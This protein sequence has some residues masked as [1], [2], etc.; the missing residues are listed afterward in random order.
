MTLCWFASQLRDPLSHTAHDLKREVN[1]ARHDIQIQPV[2]SWKEVRRGF[3]QIFPA[4]SS[5]L[6][7]NSGP[8]RSIKLGQINIS[9]WWKEETLSPNTRSFI[10]FNCWGLT[11]VGRKGSKHKLSR[12]QS[13]ILGGLPWNW[14][15][16]SSFSQDELWL[17]NFPY[18]T[19]MKSDFKF[20]QYF[21]FSFYDPVP[22]KLSTISLC[23]T[24]LIAMMLRW[25]TWSTLFLCDISM[26]FSVIV[27]M[28]ALRLKHRL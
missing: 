9:I 3:D 6:S 19:T 27:S 28:L 25:R 23:F 15:R 10:S 17:D 2:V 8:Y 4:V 21:L 20:A 12:D 24:L 16:Y 5:Q 11:A 18:R 22:T 7:K 14:N 1:A 26:F 13:L